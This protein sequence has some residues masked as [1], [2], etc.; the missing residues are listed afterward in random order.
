MLA[1]SLSSARRIDDDNLMMMMMMM[2][3]STF[4]GH[5]S[6]NVNAQCAQGSVCVCV[7]GGWGGLGGV[8]NIDLKMPV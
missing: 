7:S 1:G 8:K 5:D 4:I 2:M 3:L 6:I